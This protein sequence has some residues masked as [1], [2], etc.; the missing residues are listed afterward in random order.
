MLF[1]SRV[2]LPGGLGA[3]SQKLVEVLQAKHRERM[4]WG[5]TVTS[6]VPG[7]GVVNVTYQHN[8]KLITIAAKAVL[9]CTPK[10]ITSRVVAGIPSDQKM[11]MQQIRYTPYPVVNL[12]FDKPV[13]SRGFDTWC[14]GSTLADVVVADWTARNQPGYQQKY[15]ILTVYAPLRESQ[16]SKLLAENDCKTLAAAVLRDFQGLLS[17]FQVDPIEVHLYRRGHAM[18]MP[19]PG[20]FTKTIPVA[21]VPIDRIFFGNADSGGPESLTSEAIRISRA[22]AAWA[23]KVLAGKPSAHEFAVRALAATA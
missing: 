13:F 5:A 2:T 11:A 7:K 12:I 19:T 8:Q 23:E 1:R 4:L 3:L 15:N 17:E 9:M 6:V 22:G 10:F 16:R 18:F 21:R 14:P 20:T